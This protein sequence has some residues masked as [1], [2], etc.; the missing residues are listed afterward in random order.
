MSRTNEAV[1]ERMTCHVE[2]GAEAA[3]NS[4]SNRSLE[5]LE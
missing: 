5:E 2:D 1:L 3:V 4:G